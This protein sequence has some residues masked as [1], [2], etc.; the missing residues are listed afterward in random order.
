MNCSQILIFYTRLDWIISHK[1]W[2]PLFRLSSTVYLWLMMLVERNV[3]ICIVVLVEINYIYTARIWSP[4]KFLLVRGERIIGL[5][6]FISAITRS[7]VC[8]LTVFLFEAHGLGLFFSKAL[9]DNCSIL[10]IIRL[11]SNWALS[12]FFIAF[13]LKQF[14]TKSRNGEVS[15]SD[16]DSLSLSDIENFLDGKVCHLQASIWYVGFYLSQ[17]SGYLNTQK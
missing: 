10:A 6:L 9:L 13:I 15:V 17:S 5:Q 11:F 1:L 2:P 14:L 7:S 12:T 8:I 16:Q 4:A 3:V